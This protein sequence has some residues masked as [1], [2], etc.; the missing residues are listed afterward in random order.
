MKTCTR[1]GASKLLS[2]FNRNARSRDGRRS[3]CRTCQRDADR[4]YVR[5]PAVRRRRVETSR[6]WNASLAEGDER[7][8]RKRARA[9]ARRAKKAMQA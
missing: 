3:A 9:R 5:Q 1:C 4:A 6:Q 8:E 7:L 2:E